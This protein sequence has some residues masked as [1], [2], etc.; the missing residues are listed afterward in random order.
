MTGGDRD[1]RQ[2]D[3]FY[4][5]PPACV[6][7][8]LKAEQ[9]LPYRIWEPACGDGAICDVLQSSLMPFI[10]TDIVDRGYIGMEAQEDFLLCEKQ[11][12]ECIITNPPFALAEKFIRHA[13]KLDIKYMA[14]LLKTS[15]WHASRRAPLFEMWQPARI[16]AMTWRPDFRSLGAPTMDCI[17]CVWD[18]KSAKTE[19][20]ILPKE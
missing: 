10:A 9:L 5:T 8:L 2:K 13:H 15:F 1:T 7:A 4:A 18:G 20:R 19:Y 3:D 17:W 16:Y 6:V 11:R 14:L 12:A